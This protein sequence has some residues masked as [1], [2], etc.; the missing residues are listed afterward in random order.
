MPPLP[1]EGVSQPQDTATV[2][3]LNAVGGSPSH[4]GTESGDP[5]KVGMRVAG[6]S[7][8]RWLGKHHS[9]RS[10]PM[11]REDMAHTLCRTLAPGTEAGPVVSGAV[12]RG[13]CG[14]DGKRKG[15]FR[16]LFLSLLK[17]GSLTGFAFG[18]HFPSPQLYLQHDL[19][20][21]P[22]T[23]RPFCCPR[24]CHQVTV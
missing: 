13:M 10:Q 23:R 11:A 17:P 15:V 5:F 4:G 8:E 6:V 14:P 2:L 19:S 22:L 12:F 18:F 16:R 21:A 1:G 24:K 20:D 7:A 9:P 3:L